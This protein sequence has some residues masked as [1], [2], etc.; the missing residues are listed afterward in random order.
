MKENKKSIGFITT[1]LTLA[2]TAAGLTAYLINAG[3][4]Y[5]SNLGK[6]PV[7]IGCLAV[8]A[9]ALIG[10]IALAPAGRA[11]WAD[12]LAPL[13]PVLTVIAL[14]QLLNSRVNGIASIMT[15]TKNAQ[16]MADLSSCIAAI[17]L[18]AA[19]VLIGMLNAFLDVRK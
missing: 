16:N 1:I 14:M 2:V 19:A 6:S 7:I 5:F 11:G 18:L 3:T 12:V 10:W 8:A 13:A 17:A 15:F 9:A 4:A